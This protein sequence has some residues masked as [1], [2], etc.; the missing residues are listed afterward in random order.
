MAAFPTHNRVCYCLAGLAVAWVIAGLI[1]SRDIFLGHLVH[2]LPI[3]IAL[4]IIPYRPSW[5]WPL[6]VPL[7]SIWFIA[8]LSIFSSW[9]SSLQ[10]MSHFTIPITEAVMVSLIALLA[11]FGTFLAFRVVAI[12]GIK[13]RIGLLLMSTGTQMIALVLGGHLIHLS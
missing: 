7:F 2:S 8:A 12:P 13:G 10:A 1:Y 4:A 11:L 5:T 6:A 9:R 3:F